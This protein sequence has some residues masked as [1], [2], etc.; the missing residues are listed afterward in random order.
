MES[1]HTYPETWHTAL[2]E[3]EAFPATSHFAQSVLR[4]RDAVDLQ[5][6]GKALTVSE[7]L[8]EIMND[9]RTRSDGTI[10]ANE[11]KSHCKA[12]L[13]PLGNT[14]KTDLQRWD[15]S[16]KHL[17]ANCPRGTVERDAVED[18]ITVVKYT[19]AIVSKILMLI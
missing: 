1:S 13:R 18:S 8:V 2:Q 10:M 12:V 3:L 15:L 5:D 14:L 7:H 4:L 6:A 16:L 19:A 11:F 9:A 17:T